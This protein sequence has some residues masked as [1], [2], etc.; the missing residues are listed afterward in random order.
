MALRNHTRVSEFIFCGLTQSQELSLLLFLF[1]A[2]IYVT[3]V[4]ANVAIMV[5][6]TCEPRLHP[7]VLPAPQSLCLGHLLLLHH[8]SEGP[9]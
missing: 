7:H 5:T 1:L 4:L 6:V 2:V 3:T 8:C 9:S